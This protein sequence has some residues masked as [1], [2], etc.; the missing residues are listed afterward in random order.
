MNRQ[1]VKFSEM[2]EGK[3]NKDLDISFQSLALEGRFK[4]YIIISI[5]F[6]EVIDC[7]N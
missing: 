6:S 5:H 4:M 3:A 1:E 7:T 2:V